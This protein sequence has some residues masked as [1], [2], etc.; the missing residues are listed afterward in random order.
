MK[1]VAFNDSPRSKGNTFAA[2]NIVLASL[3][4]EGIETELVQLG[5]H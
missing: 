1:V 5:R 3:E 2:L 4:K